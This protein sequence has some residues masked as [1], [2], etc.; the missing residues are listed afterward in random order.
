MNIYR[1][2]KYLWCWDITI[3]CE[4][5]CY[6]LAETEKD[7]I[8]KVNGSNIPKRIY[9]DRGLDLIDVIDIV[10]DEHRNILI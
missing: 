9:S 6:V 1:F 2:S 5:W 4:P 8:S 7:A 3:G 10:P